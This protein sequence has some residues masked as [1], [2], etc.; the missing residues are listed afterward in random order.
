MS[1][2]LKALK[3]RSGDLSAMLEEIESANKKT[4]ESDRDDSLYW[5]PTVDKA[6]NGYAVIRFL[7]SPDTDVN[8]QKYWDHGFKGPTGRWYIEKSRTSIGENDPV[9]EM[10][11]E[12]WSQ[13]EEGQKIARER[14]R[15]L[16]HVANIQVVTD[17]DNPQNEGKV[18]LYEYGKKIQGKIDESLKPEF[19]DE[20]PMNPFDLWNG[21][22]FAIKIRQVEGYRN[23]DK[24]EF[25]SPSAVYD[26]D[27]TKL[28]E[29]V[30][31]L[32][33]LSFV[34]DPKNYKSYDDLRIRLN[35]VLGSEDSRPASTSTGSTIKDEPSQPVSETKLQDSN[36]DKEDEDDVMARFNRLANGE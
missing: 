21:A 14:K 3:S 19:P 34:T 31:Q 4:F 2:D 35:S 20:E 23:Y 15:R 22:D 29:L 28:Q 18:F 36:A 7:P 33:E 5:K 16:K 6:G 9:G 10:N 17:T 27:E 1:I 25:K 30:D 8:W 13:G 12:L 24:S 11:S 32:N 26:G